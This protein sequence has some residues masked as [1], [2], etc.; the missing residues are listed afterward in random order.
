[1]AVS[2]AIGWFFEQEAEGIILEDDCL[3]APAFFNFCD[4][5]LEKYRNDTQDILH[6]RF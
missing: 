4:N 2:S 5:L 6:H 1:M 3:P